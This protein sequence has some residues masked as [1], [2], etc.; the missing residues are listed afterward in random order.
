MSREAGS[1]GRGLSDLRPKRSFK[2]CLV[3]RCFSRAGTTF[4]RFRIVKLRIVKLRVVKPVLHGMFK[5]TRNIFKFSILDFLKPKADTG[6]L[7]RHKLFRR[8]IKKVI[9]AEQM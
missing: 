1:S 8:K 3:C 5:T 7:S 4:S 2:K 6:N 9:T